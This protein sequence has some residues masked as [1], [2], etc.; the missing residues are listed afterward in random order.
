MLFLSVTFLSGV[1]RVLLLFLDIL[2]RPQG[3]SSEVS[4]KP[5]STNTELIVQRSGVIKYQLILVSAEIT[6]SDR[7]Q[8]I[9]EINTCVYAETKF[10]GFGQDFENWV[11]NASKKRF[12][13]QGL[14]P[15]ADSNRGL[16]SLVGFWYHF[17]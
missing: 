15:N 4:N 8:N 6:L 10:F 9:P 17:H 1:Y 2:Y 5:F 12:H 11:S 13:L 3:C 16:M 14:L 7:T